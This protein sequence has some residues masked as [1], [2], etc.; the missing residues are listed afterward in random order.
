MPAASRPTRKKSKPNH[1]PAASS[2]QLTPTPPPPAADDDDDDDDFEP[3]STPAPTPAR[4]TP[5]SAKG[6]TRA[7]DS[8]NEDLFYGKDS[9]VE[10]FTQTAPLPSER[11]GMKTNKPRSLRP[12]WLQ[13]AYQPPFFGVPLAELAGDVVDEDTGQPSQAREV[14]PWPKDGVGRT[15]LSSDAYQRCKVGLVRWWFGQVGWVPREG[16]YDW[17][18][19]PGKGYGWA[20]GIRRSNWA[21]EARR[22]L[23]VGQAPTN[24]GERPGWPFV[25]PWLDPVFT[26][27]IPTDAYPYLHD[28]HTPRHTPLRHPTTIMK[29]TVPELSMRNRLKRSVIATPSKALKKSRDDDEAAEDDASGDDDD[30]PSSGVESN[31]EPINRSDPRFANIP[32]LGFEEKGPICGDVLHVSVGHPGQETPVHIEK[33]TSRRH[34]SVGVVPEEGHLMNVGGHVYALDWV[35]IPIHL[36][37]GR[38]FFVISAAPSNSPLTMIGEKTGKTPAGLQIWSVSPDAEGGKKGVARLEMVVC[39]EAGTAFKLAWCPVG[40]DFGDMAEDKE[41]PQRLGLLAG[42]FADG[43]IS[44]FSV[45]HPDS[46]RSTAKGVSSLEPVH[47][48]LE[49]ILRLTHPQQSA[50]SLAWAGGE[51]LAFGGSQGWLGVW[52]VGHLLRSPSPPP[53][54]PPPSYVVRAHRSAITD[55]TFILLPPLS[56]DGVALTSSP[57]LSL[58]SVSL[59][60]LTSHIDLSRCAS[61]SIERSRTVHYACA[62]SAFS[63]GSLVHEHADGSVAHYSLRPEEMLRSRTVTHTPSRVLALATSAFHPMLAAGTAHGELKVANVLRTMKRCQ[64]NHLPIYQQVVDRSTG[65]LVVK[66]HL[67]PEVANQAESKKFHIAQWHPKLAVT[68]VRWNPNMGRCRLVL[69]GTAA[70]LVKVDFV[71]PPFEE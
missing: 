52:N 41:V 7:L 63:G 64:R 23:L 9:D 66:H 5:R 62:F 33:G 40:H 11:A 69:S 6:K 67:L 1:S 30:N 53:I 21:K 15:C 19:W 59:D 29:L 54:T 35:P 28:P 34:D 44:V 50:T 58:F 45:P 4:R 38:E 12:L 57:P 43:S 68:A 20:E 37:T 10:I 22:N 3:P 36:D 39:H 65:E 46:A 18:W 61:V 31:Q 2:S 13:G 8:D 55:L 47:I 16:V 60:G 27:L 24:E 51:L 14:L 49:P 17:G 32:N 71:K 25:Q 26:V 48:R 42:C 70:G 56:S